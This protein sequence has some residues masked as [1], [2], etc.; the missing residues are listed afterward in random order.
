MVPKYGNGGWNSE[1]PP[2]LGDT[3]TVTSWCGMRLGKDEFAVEF[4]QEYD[5]SW[6]L[7]AREV[8]R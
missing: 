6:K 1:T 2:K 8:K 7:T 3:L 5:D 4:V